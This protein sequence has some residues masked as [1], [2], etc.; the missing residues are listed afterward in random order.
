MT[1][2]NNSFKINSFLIKL[3]LIA[4]VVFMFSCRQ[5]YMKKELRVYEKGTI[6]QIRSQ[7]KGESVLVSYTDHNNKK[8]ISQFNAAPYSLRVSEKYWISYNKNSFEDVWVFWTAP[9][10]D[11]TSKYELSTGYINRSWVS[12]F[13]NHN[14]CGLV[15]EYKGKSY[16]RELRLVDKTIKKGDKV[17]VL[18][19]KKRPSIAYVKGSSAITK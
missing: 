6:V 5:E 2:K 8:H 7:H 14:S 1:K 15:Y 11:D 17:E 19:N 16:E 13:D 10:I 4:S 18:I 3:F 9:I 12:D